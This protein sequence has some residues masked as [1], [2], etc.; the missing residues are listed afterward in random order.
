MLTSSGCGGTEP[1][2]TQVKAVAARLGIDAS[3][4]RVIVETPE[5]ARLLHSLGS[6]TFLVNGRDLDP[7]ARDRTD[8]G[9]G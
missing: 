6:P 4:D 2:I 5:D 9:L 7:S 8:Y 3:I 1:A